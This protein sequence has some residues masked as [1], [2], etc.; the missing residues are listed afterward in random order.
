MLWDG[1]ISFFKD[2]VLASSTNKQL[3]QRLLDFRARTH[4]DD[5]PPVTLL[6]GQETETVI[7]HS[8]MRLKVEQQEAAEAAKRKAALE[9]EEIEDDDDG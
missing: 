7:R 9:G 2:A 8:L 4:N 3:V 5:E 1:S 6:H